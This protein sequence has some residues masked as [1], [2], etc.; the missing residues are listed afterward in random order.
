M[1][2]TNIFPLER[3]HYFYGKLLTVRDFEQEQRYMN[4]KRRLIN[5]M[6]YGAGVVA[7][8]GVTKSDDATLLVE[9]GMALDYL[10]REIVLPSPD[11]KAL[12]M[13]PG[14]DEILGHSQAFLCLR[15]AEEMREPVNAIGAEAGKSAE[16]N[17]YAETYGLYLDVIDPDIPA[18]LDGDG[19]TTSTVLYQGDGAW[20]V[21]SLPKAVAASEEFTAECLLMKGA[22]LLPVSIALELESDFFTTVDEKKSIRLEFSESPENRQDVYRIPFRLRASEAQGILTK[23]SSA[24]ASFSIRIGDEKT[25]TAVTL[26]QDIFICRDTAD[27]QD[28][29]QQQ[30]NMASHWGADLPIYLAKLDLIPSTATALI[31]EVINLPFA[32][33]IRV[34]QTSQAGGGTQQ[35]RVES[36]VNVLKYWQ[37]PEVQS[38]YNEATGTLQFRFGLPSTVAND[39]ATTSGVVEIPF[40]DGMRVNG[41]YYSEEIPHNLGSGNVNIT[42]AVEFGEGEDQGL[43]FGNAE[44]FASKNGDK[45]IPQIET[46]AVLYPERGTFKIGV[47][48]MDSV[49]ASGVRIR[50]FASKVTNDI[51]EMKKTNAVVI[52][53]VPEIQRIKVRERLHL[54]AVVTGAED[55]KVTWVVKDK[56]GGTIDRQGIYNAPDLPGT[57]EVVATSAADGVTAVSAFVIVEE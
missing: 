12:N 38:K 15:Y 6:I 7:G 13:L 17:K 32:Q 50:Y 16:C 25:S 35:I 33:R 9:S 14:Y 5:R 19:T 51:E 47:W 52:K 41:R 29:L 1:K 46:G 43:F 31:R 57:Y 28:Y 24:P 23:L 42:L 37:K 21:L 45:A 56:N 55:K 49:G 53:I 30:E 36:N 48:L 54:K 20:V 8:L 27:V 44:V 40:T 22:E 3:N 11:I 18:L 4:N 39:Y 2:N 10:G 26:D 34:G